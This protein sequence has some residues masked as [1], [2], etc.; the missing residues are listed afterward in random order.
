MTDPTGK[1]RPD[2]PFAPPINVELPVARDRDQAAKQVTEA[3]AKFAELKRAYAESSDQKIA[4]DRAALERLR[5]DPYHLNKVLGGSAAARD[6]EQAL[7]ARIAV[8]EAEAARDDPR[9]SL[10]ATIRDFKSLDAASVGEK[11]DQGVSTI[12]TTFEGQLPQ[13]DL[14]AAIEPLVEHGMKP[15]MIE[16]F[17]QSG[18]S[19]G[20]DTRQVEIAAANEWLRRLMADPELQKKFLAGTDPE[21]RRQFDAFAIYAPDPRKA[22]SE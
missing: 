18:R 17:L 7:R 21:L 20:P 19:G 4:R 13:G 14:A 15:E 16:N 1:F 9:R 5:N 8:A 12:E 2:P 11:L 6:D 3:N 10:K 22:P